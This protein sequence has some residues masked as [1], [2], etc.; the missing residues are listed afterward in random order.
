[1]ATQGS[2]PRTARFSVLVTRPYMLSCDTTMITAMTTGVT[3]T[4]VAVCREASSL[5]DQVSGAAADRGDDK[6]GGQPES[7]HGRQPSAARIAVQVRAPGVTQVRMALPGQGISTPSSE[8]D[9]HAAI[10]PEPGEPRGGC[11]NL[12]WIWI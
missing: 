4:R 8:P 9:G 1:M 12:I 7:P 10:I 3:M 5:A 11:V 2:P 6:P